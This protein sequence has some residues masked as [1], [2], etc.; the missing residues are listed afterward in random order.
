[1]GLFS[2]EECAF[3]GNK[4][5]F[6]SRKKLINNEGYVCKEC[7]K[8]CS[9][10][11]NVS[12]FTR[13][14]LKKHMEYMEKENKLYE[15]A[16]VPIDKKNKQRFVTISTG[17]EC[18]DE[19]AMFRYVSPQADKKVYK[20]LF[21]YDQIKSY[22]EYYK[23]NTNASNGKKYSEVGL[24][25][26]LNCSR[27]QFGESAGSVVG[28]GSRNYHPYVHEIQVPTARDTD[29]FSH[30]GLKDHLDKVFG[31]YEDN[32]FVGGIKSSIV[33]TNKERQERKVAGEGF[34]ALGNLAKAKITGNEE[35]AEKA[36]DSLNTLKNDAAD[37]V[38]HNRA[39]LTRTAN[40]VEDRILGNEKL[41]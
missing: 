33:G 2:K 25:I 14:E 20:E 22:E 11:I 34:K 28:A 1:M 27:P 38:T 12:H 21:R 26:H 10:L 15:E 30:V 6:F 13:D 9:A 32:S 8:K 16:F 41:V 39:S 18:A 23:E 3:C 29:S 37:L 4:V 35:D 24:T 7:E 40:E 19:I 36:K 31:V 5:G 17:I